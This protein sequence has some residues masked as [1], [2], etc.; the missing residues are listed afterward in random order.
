MERSARN[1]RV[2]ENYDEP[3]ITMQQVKQL[4]RRLVQAGI[5]GYTAACFTTLMHECGH[6][7]AARILNGDS[8]TIHFNPKNPFRAFV[9]YDYNHARFNFLSNDSKD[10]II[11]A[12]GP[13][14]GFAAAYALLKSANIVTEYYKKEKP[15][16]KAIKDGMKK[17]LFHSDVDPL[18][19]AIIA[20]LGYFASVYQLAPTDQFRSDG[21]HILDAL[22]IPNPVVRYPQL[23][24]GLF[25]CQSY[26]SL[27]LCPMLA[28]ALHYAYEDEDQENGEQS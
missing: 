20:S 26:I 15:L 14:C 16:G 9:S 28:I 5:T 10:I 1:T 21:D 27:I 24:I 6:W 2:E 25:V 23:G 8:A 11:N 22:D 4:P 13:I 18:I 12:A 17:R 3:L 7:T 19:Q